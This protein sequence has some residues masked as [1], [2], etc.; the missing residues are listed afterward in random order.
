MRLYVSGPMR[1]L[2]EFNFPEFRGAAKA[3]RAMG[4]EVFNPVERDEEAGL[5]TKGLCGFEDLSTLGFDL[6]EALRDDLHIILF[7]ADAVVVLRGWENSKGAQAEV[8]TAR[9]VGKPILALVPVGGKF[10]LV[11]VK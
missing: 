9:A 4:H 10:F 7:D 2:A 3:L 1:G 8:A 11:E 6:A 5:D